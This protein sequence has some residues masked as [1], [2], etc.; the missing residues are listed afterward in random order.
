[1][2]TNEIRFNTFLNGLDNKPDNPLREDEQL[3]RRTLLKVVGMCA[4]SDDSCDGTALD[5]A[6]RDESYHLAHQRLSNLIGESKN[7][8][9]ACKCN[10]ECAVVLKGKGFECRCNIPIEECRPIDGATELYLG[11][12]HVEKAFAKL[13]EG[14][15]TQVDVYWDLAKTKTIDFAIVVGGKTG[16]PPQCPEG[17]VGGFCAGIPGIKFQSPDGREIRISLPELMARAKGEPHHV[18]EYEDDC[19]RPTRLVLKVINQRG[20]PALAIRMNSPWT[21]TLTRRTV[22]RIMEEASKE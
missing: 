18:Q 6:R 19:P 12:L 13:F 9:M 5:E 16:F 20:D 21:M 3:L 1:M 8:C 4:E 17:E 11:M 7:F 2:G 14:H 10:E 22:L 15:E